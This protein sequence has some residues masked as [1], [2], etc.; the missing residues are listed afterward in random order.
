MKIGLLSCAAWAASIPLATLSNQAA[1]QSAPT[2][3]ESESQPS[4]APSPAPDKGEIV[5][6][7]IRGSLERA[8]EIKRDAVQ[9]VDSIVAQDIGKLPDPTTAAALQRVPGVQVSVN[10]NNELGDVRVRGLPDVLTTVDG[11]EIFTTTGRKLDLQALPAE[12]LARVDVYKSQTPDLIEGGL[13]GSID[14]RLNKPFSFNKPTVV[15]SARGNYGLRADKGDP[16]LG[17][18]VTDRWHTGIGEIG[19]LLNVTWSRSSYERDETILSGLRS[20][21]ATPLNTAG[22]LVPNI[23]QNFPEQGRLWRTQA[24]AAIGWR[25]SPS[26]E[27]YLDGLYTRMR[28]RGAH[29]GANVQPFTTNVTMTNVQASNNCFQSR[30]TAAGQN[31]TIQ[32]DAAGN[33]TLQA[34]T[35]QNLCYLNSATFNNVVVNQT[36][37]ARDNLEQNKLVAGGFRFDRDGWKANVDISYQSSRADNAL[38]IADIGQRLP[39]LTLTTNDDG[40][41]GFGVPGNALLTTDNLYIRNSFQQNFS[42]TQ[43]DLFA[44]KADG[45]RELGGLLT[46]FKVGARYAARTA[47]SQSVVLNTPFP[48][49]NIGTAT[50]ATAV[51]VLATGLPA[52]FLSIGSPAPS[53]NGGVAFYVPDPDFL[54]SSAGQDALRTYVGLPTGRPAFQKT[55]QFNSREKTYSAYAELDYAIPVATG[56]VIDGVVGGRYVRTERTVTTFVASGTTFQPLSAT[57]T[58]NDFLPTVTARLKLDNGIQARL[59]FS[60]SIRRPEFSDLNPAVTLSLSNNP[61]VQSGGSAGNPNLREQKSD[62]YDATLEYYFRGGYVAVAGYYRKITDR[63]ISGAA[64]ETYNGIDYSVTRPRNLGKAT[65]KGVEVSSQYFL[66]FLP[67]ALS[68]VGLQGTFTLA[69]SEIGGSDPLAGNPLQGVSKYNFTAGLLYEKFGISGRLV[70][71]YRSKY[72]DSDQ[73]GSISVRPITADQVS[74]VFVPTLLSYVRPAGRLDFNIGYDVTPAIRLDVGGTNILRNKTKDYLGRSY[75][76]FEGFYDETIYSVGVR[77]RL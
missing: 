44:V 50:E 24:N 8:A 52:D 63:V 42:V 69:D 61:F 29:Y 30:V 75:E 77:I 70:Y 9:V 39:S 47:D 48:K 49:G 19:A 27:V 60:R 5:V 26:L 41:A 31:P 51:K 36:T 32:T 66:D 10:R 34:Y 16:Q 76:N 72:F 73:T 4:A 28:D 71:T 11:R 56:V 12:A 7:G 45:E 74:T 13:A 55:R 43:G 1:A 64:T 59:G 2:S 17:L 37:Q 65:L 15:L 23:L 33:K 46:A 53:I 18:L 62:S 22:Y 20:S 58:D 67:G 25:P 57:T 35:L 6:T 40:I 14:L 3:P 21:A 38:V 68:G 54:L